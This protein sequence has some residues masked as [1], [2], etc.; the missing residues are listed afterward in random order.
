[1]LDSK[2]KIEFFVCFDTLIKKL[3]DY[4]WNILVIRTFCKY[5]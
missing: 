4:P 2:R 3:V 5:R 1:M